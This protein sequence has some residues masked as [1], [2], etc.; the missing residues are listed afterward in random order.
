MNFVFPWPQNI[1][2]GSAPLLL[3]LFV[4]R[5]EITGYQT[6]SNQFIISGLTFGVYDITDQKLLYYPDELLP[7]N[8][9]LLEDDYN[10]KLFGKI[11]F[12]L[13]NQMI[14]IFFFFSNEI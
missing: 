14:S 11:N 6:T 4:I 2:C 8:P 7:F 3:T 9:Q 1:N 13:S 12:Q 10:E 5:E